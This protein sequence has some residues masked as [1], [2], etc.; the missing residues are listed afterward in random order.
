MAKLIITEDSRDKI[1]EITDSEFTIGS[2]DDAD[3]PL[4][5]QSID[6][7]HLTVTKSKNGYRIVDMETRVG[8][9]VNGDVVNEHILGNGDTL[10]LGE[11]KITY[12]G[13]EKR[14]VAGGG[15]ARANRPR[16]DAGGM[17]RHYRHESWDQKMSPAARG[18]VIGGIVLAAVVVLWL[19]LSGSDTEVDHFKLTAKDARIAL[20]DRGSEGIPDAKEAIK[21]LKSMAE[22][23]ADRRKIQELERMLKEREKEASAIGRG[24]A[25]RKLA[26]RLKRVLKENPTNYDQQREYCKEYLAKYDDLDLEREEKLVRG[27]LDNVSNI[28]QT[29]EEKEFAALV[30]KAK[31]FERQKLFQDATAV[32]KGASDKLRD[33]FAEEIDA[34][35]LWFRKRS[36]MILTIRKNEVRHGLRTNDQALI[37]KEM[38]FIFSNLVIDVVDDYLRAPDKGYRNPENARLELE[39]QKLLRARLKKER[40]R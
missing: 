17:Q 33:L 37:D 11:V 1:F 31:D 30:G 29:P 34:K 27:T 18:G 25:A 36:R 5:D 10:Q 21:E 22:S 12:I 26:Q 40:G 39:T 8:T 3:C 35:L 38:D 19:M 4:R 28:K 9:R 15:A 6:P 7:I 20:T 2:S 32:M 24:D 16:V 14:K 13:A 23:S